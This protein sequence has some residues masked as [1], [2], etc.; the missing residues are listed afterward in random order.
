MWGAGGVWGSERQDESGHVFRDVEGGGSAMSCHSAQR[1]RGDGRWIKGLING[2][3]CGVGVCSCDQCASCICVVTRVGFIPPFISV[4]S[5]KHP[6]LRVVS[7][8]P[9]GVA[10]SSGKLHGAEEG[11]LPATCIITSHLSIA[12]FVNRRLKFHPPPSSPQSLNL[13]I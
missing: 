9:L 7:R 6:I 3:W 13:A 2:C 4:P 5:Q 8:C 1:F 10:E 12:V 11:R